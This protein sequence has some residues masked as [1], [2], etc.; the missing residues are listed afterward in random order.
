MGRWGLLG[1]PWEI[2]GRVNPR[3]QVRDPLTAWEGPVWIRGD[4]FQEREFYPFSGA[5]VSLS[6]KWGAPHFTFL[7]RTALSSA[8]VTT[9]DAVTGFSG[10]P[11][12]LLGIT[13]CLPQN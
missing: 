2:V 3:P 1:R 9:G 11:L 7:P 5:S 13:P 6:G 8:P 12:I 4:G 10:T